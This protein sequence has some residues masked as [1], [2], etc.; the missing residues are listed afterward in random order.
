MFSPTVLAGVL[1]VTLTVDVQDL[2]VSPASAPSL[3]KPP[4]P[5]HLSSSVDNT[6]PIS[7][8]LP[9]TLTVDDQDLIVSPAS[10]P[11]LTKPPS[12][13]HLGSNVSKTGPISPQLVWGS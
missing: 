7:L 6:G 4:S 3:T 1:P 12:S 10:A 5:A 9:V 2:I 13:A 11:S 8:H